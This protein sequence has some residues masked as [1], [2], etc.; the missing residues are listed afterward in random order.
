[1]M[2]STILC[3]G[4]ADQILISYYLQKVLGYEYIKDKKLK[5][6]LPSIDIDN[7]ISEWY[8]DQKENKLLILEVGGNKFDKCLSSLLKYNNQTE[9]TEMFRRI[10][11]ITDNDDKDAYGRI[12]QLQS[13][14][15]AYSN[16]QI[17]LKHAEWND[18]TM[19]SGFDESVTLSLLFLLQPTD[20]YGNIET[21][22]LDMHATKNN[23]DKIIVD[24]ARAYIS[25]VKNACQKKYLQTRGEQNKGELSAFFAV[26]SPQHIFSPINDLL[27]A[28]DWQEYPNYNEQYRLLSDI[29]KEII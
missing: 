13:A 1:M 25:K 18:F 11:V 21:F 3:E 2:Y 22:I 26:I 4:I 23:D 17:S 10:C 29:N 7:L 16:K 14:A 12:N 8:I 19:S 6:S 20:S 15:Q 5:K 28:I 27:R 24:E 9:A